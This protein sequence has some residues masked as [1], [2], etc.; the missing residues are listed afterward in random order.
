MRAAVLPGVGAGWEVRELPVP[1]PGP[2]AV[3]IRVRASSI[4]VNDVL[5]SRGA[6]PFPGA[7]PAVPGHEPVGEVV[8]VGPG[9]TSRQ[10]GDR[11]G[12]TWVQG[13][14][15]RCAYCRLQ[16]PLTGQTALNCAAPRTL[17]FSVPGGQAEY[18]VAEAAATVLLPDDL[19]YELAAP[20]MCAGYTAW[21]AL[22]QADPRP[23]ERVAVLGIGAL[24]HLA[25]QYA[26]ACGF[27][28]VAVTRSPDKREVA[29]Q[30]GADLVVGDGAQLRDAGGADV[31]LVTASSY[32]AASDSLRGLRV[33]GRLVLAGLDAPG[34]FDLA[35]ERGRPF[36]AQR[37]RIIGTTHNGLPDLVEALRLV[38]AGR[39][40][41]MVEVVKPDD[42]PT[43]VDRVAGGDVRFRA[44]VSW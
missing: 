26:S 39:C 44:V 37:H 38:A 5:A 22:R 18:V 31:V 15:G 14:C 30:L 4:C 9:V 6:L 3:L 33:D 35:P 1:R 2:G 28:T 41:P 36:F 10:V 24:G 25:V 29:R 7:D 17:G 42:L 8:A 16:R 20:V 40:T 12:A 11:V 21:G 23:H 13:A 34:G 27:E 43:A 32:R 19:P